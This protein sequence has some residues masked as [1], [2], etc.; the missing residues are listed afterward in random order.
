MIN[1]N[2]STH[3]MVAIQNDSMII[4]ELMNSCFAGVT[5]VIF[6]KTALV[7]TMPNRPSKLKTIPN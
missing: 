5:L 7:T 4:M 2:T 3:K 6:R 1:R